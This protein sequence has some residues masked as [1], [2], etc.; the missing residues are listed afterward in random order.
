M[1][2]FYIYSLSN[3]SKFVIIIVIGHIYLMITT[4][5]MGAIIAQQNF[6]MNLYFVRI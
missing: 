2:F 3:Q 6:K 4:K 1:M 5:E